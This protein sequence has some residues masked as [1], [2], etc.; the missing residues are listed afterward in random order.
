MTPEERI[1][2]YLRAELEH[3]RAAVD[4][5]VAFLTGKAREFYWTLSRLAGL[6]RLHDGKWRTPGAEEAAK[7]REGLN[8]DIPAPPQTGRLLIDVTA[9]HRYRKQTGVQRVVREIAR[10]CVENG[11]GLPVYIENGRLFSHFRHENLPDEVEVAAGD[12]L[13][14]LDSGWGFHDEYPPLIA[15]ARHAGAEVV[16]CLYDLIP[17]RYPAAV[18]PANGRAFVHWFETV[19]MNCDALACISKSVADDFTAYLRD[20]GRAAPDRLRIGWWP[21]GADFRAPASGAPSEKV[22]ALASGPSP[23]FLSVGTL[24]PRK[25]YPVALAAFEQLWSEGHDIRYVIVGRRGWSTNALERRILRHPQYGTR[26][27]WLDDASDAD[28]HC[29]YRQA[30]ALVFT[31]FVEGFG[32]PLVEAAHHGAHVIASDIPVFREIGGE[33]V[34]YFPLLDSDAL[35]AR[36]VAALERSNAAARLDVVSWRESAAALVDMTRRGGYQISAAALRDA[37]AG[38]KGAQYA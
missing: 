22:A 26:L 5:R 30:R 23:Y 10:A 3:E 36:V 6:E 28:L 12:R 11:E 2:A 14:L 31:S 37:V 25:A 19:L 20:S 1:D 33:G 9:T 27:F 29:L 4:P 35:A 34:D 15:T 7:L 13:L 18:E 24:E 38:S 8:G 32:M 17:L 16:G 21:L